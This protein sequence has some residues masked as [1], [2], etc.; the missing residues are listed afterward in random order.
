MDF[1]TID[2]ETA[3]ADRASICQVG[4]VR[5]ENGKI[6]D[7]W[8]TLVNPESWFDGMNMSIHGICE[9]DV[10]HSP[11]MPQIRDE[12]RRRLRDSILVSHTSF[13]RV[14]VERSMEKYELEQL[15]VRWLDSAAI[16]R[17]AW[18]EEFAQQGYGLAD[19]AES[20]G[21]SFNHHDALEDARAVAEIVIRACNETDTDIEKW[22]S[23]VKQPIDLDGSLS[24]KRTGRRRKRAAREPNEAGPL[25]EESQVCLFTGALA[26]MVRSQAADLAAYAGCRVVDSARAEDITRLIVGM[27]NPNVLN[28]YD[29]STKH[30]SIEKRISKGERIEICSEEDWIGVLKTAFDT[31]EVRQKINDLE[32]RMTPLQAQIEKQ[33]RS[34]K[35]RHQ[36]RLSLHSALRNLKQGW[37]KGELAR[38]QSGHAAEKRSSD[39]RSWSLDGAL[40]SGDHSP[41]PDGEIVSRGIMKAQETVLDILSQ[42]GKISSKDN[43]S[44][45]SIND[46][47]IEHQDEAIA[48]A[49]KAIFYLRAERLEGE[50]DKSQAEN[51]LGKNRKLHSTL[52]ALLEMLA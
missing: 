38:D 24:E 8:Q 28:G 43:I 25:F 2:V 1:N 33:R 11:T 6:V 13:D 40:L 17:R 35:I 49:K 51:D 50:R 10:K 21:I 5:V 16:V 45:A 7:Q 52:L 39:A 48:L 46:H 3:N 22:L 30:R 26:S 41:E 12:L 29:K 14:A 15:Q 19:V 23:R 37:C 4:I 31:E 36:A 20:L 34:F 47:K 32:R 18:P 27:Q 42:Q 44:L 9:A